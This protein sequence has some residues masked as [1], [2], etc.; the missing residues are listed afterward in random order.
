TG[1]WRSGNPP[2]PEQVRQLRKHGR[3]ET[4]RRA[5]DVARPGPPDR[6]VATSKTFR[7]LARIS[8]AAPSADGPYIRR[9]V[10]HEEVTDLAKGLAVMPADQRATLPGVSQVRAPQL[11]AGALVADAALDLLRLAPPEVSPLPPP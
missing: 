10:T 7:Q 9:S 5:A 11:A 6:A 1:D 3:A 2:A 8:G 4:A